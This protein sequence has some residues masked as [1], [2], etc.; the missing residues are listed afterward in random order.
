MRT[1]LY[2]SLYYLYD[3]V[4]LSELHQVF[5]PLPGIVSI[6]FL[7]NW[8][9]IF[10]FNFPFIL[11]LFYFYF[12]PS[13]TCSC[14]LFVV[15]AKEPIYGGLAL[16]PRDWDFF[17]STQKRTESSWKESLK[18]PWLTKTSRMIKPWRTIW[19]PL[20]KDVYLVLCGRLSKQTTLRWRHHSFSSCNKTA[21][22]L[23]YLVETLMSISANFWESVTH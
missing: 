4:Y 18:L 9:F 15:Y 20:F 22:L 19:H 11:F 7:V 14:V 6:S 10:I 21:S 12:I 8:T 23:D 17:V 16:W 3:L 2:L 13:C 1:I 5:E